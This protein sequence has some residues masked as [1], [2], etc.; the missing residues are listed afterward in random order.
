M[1]VAGLAILPEP[2]EWWERWQSLLGQQYT[3]NRSIDRRLLN[4]HQDL[5]PARLLSAIESWL[6]A[7]NNP[8]VYA[9][10]AAL[11]DNPEDLLLETDAE[12]SARVYLSMERLGY[13]LNGRQK[14]FLPAIRDQIWKVS[15]Y[16]AGMDIAQ[17]KL[18][19]ALGELQNLVA[20][21]ERM[22]V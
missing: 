10:N 7:D 18:S 21:F 16:R 17:S 4:S 22:S 19:L 9:F 20:S 14:A 13:T 1:H 5:P 2:L 15:D 8:S 6:G 12:A 11:R 3:G